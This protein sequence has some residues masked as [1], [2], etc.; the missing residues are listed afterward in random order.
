[1]SPQ[2]RYDQT[3][4]LHIENQGRPI[5][6]RMLTEYSTSTTLM[7]KVD[8]VNCSKEITSSNNRCINRGWTR[9]GGR[10][11]NNSLSKH[12]DQYV[13]RIKC[14]NVSTS[15]VQSLIQC[16]SYPV[17]VVV[18]VRRREGEM[19]GKGSGGEGKCQALLCPHR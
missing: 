19:E 2:Q 1:M 3:K 5:Q 12:G 13:H 14:A 8:P 10:S 15:A 4:E 16:D 17:C 18:L 9:G 7:N 11:P 6:V